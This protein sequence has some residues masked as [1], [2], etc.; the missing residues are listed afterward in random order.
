MRNEKGLPRSLVEEC[1]GM[2]DELAGEKEPTYLGTKDSAAVFWRQAEF[3]LDDGRRLQMADVTRRR[4]L[5]ARMFMGPL[6]AKQIFVLDLATPTD[7]Q[8]E[9]ATQYV[10]TDRSVDIATREIPERPRGTELSYPDCRTRGLGA[11]SEE[12]RSEF[13][14]T[15]TE[16]GHRYMFF[17]PESGE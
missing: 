17:F 5:A 15:I 8:S 4:S 3:G 16:L 14:S 12:Q 13:I 7:A 10:V 11:P 9:S 1:R 6:L 2:F